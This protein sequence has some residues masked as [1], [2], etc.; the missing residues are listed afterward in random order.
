MAFSVWQPNRSYRPGDIVVP[1]TQPPS[2]SVAL[3]N[4][5]FDEGATGWDFEGQ[6]QYSPKVANTVQNCAMLDYGQAGGHAWNQSRLRVPPGQP[7]TV[8]G[9]IMIKKKGRGG[10][11]NVKIRWYTAQDA[12]ISEYHSGFVAGG[13]QGWKEARVTATCPPHAAY[14]RAGF[15]LAVQN[16]NNRIL[17]AMLAVLTTAYPP[18][19]PGLAF[20]AVQEKAA[21]SAPHEPDWPRT[22]GVQV[23]D[24]GVIW[25]ALIASRLTW[26]AE[27][28]YLSGSSEP[29]WPQHVGG[30]VTDGTI[31]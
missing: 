29:D 20:R 7:L 19:P 27:P 25:E 10:G 15:E 1:R 4:G 16:S 22:T 14:A 9:S 5:N 31:T 6:V 11:G 8:R 30:R 3:A 2:Y 12:L 28:L 17:A 26:K 21:V 23:T 13:K 18:P 24:G